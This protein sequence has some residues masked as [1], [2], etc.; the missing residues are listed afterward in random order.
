MEQ[1]A[2][3]V[4]IHYLYYKNH[5]NYKKLIP[6]KWREIKGLSDKNSMA[7][8]NENEIVLAMRGLDIK[9]L[10]DVGIGVNI[11]A[12]DIMNPRGFDYETAR[13]KYK[14]ILLQEQKKI[15]MIKENYP[16]KKLI[17]AG[18][19]RGGRKAV[20]LGMHNDVE[21]HGFNSGDASSLR[22]KIYSLAL[23]YILGQLDT[24]PLSEAIGYTLTAPSLYAE[25]FLQSG[26]YEGVSP[27]GIL[28]K[29]GFINLM[30]LH[31]P[32]LNAGLRAG[33]GDNPI[34]TAGV[35][36]IQD[37]IQPLKNELI[38]TTIAGG[39]P[40]KT[41]KY[42]FPDARLSG[43][44]Y[45]SQENMVKHLH[46]QGL[47][48]QRFSVENHMERLRRRGIPVDG[49][50]QDYAELKDYTGGI[51]GKAFN[52]EKNFIEF[53]WATTT[54]TSLDNKKI[55]EGDELISIIQKGFT[56]AQQPLTATQPLTKI[57]TNNGNLY[58]TE[59]DIVSSGYKGSKLQNLIGVRPEIVAPKDYV[60]GFDPTHHSIDHFISKELF[61]AIK[62]NET[63]TN[64]LDQD[65]IIKSRFHREE[66]YNNNAFGSEIGNVGGSGREKLNIN[67][68]CNAF[69]D[70][71]ECKFF[72]GSL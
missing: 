62:K 4:K 64:V 6:R 14:D 26:D 8:E 7:F 70:L 56:F 42:G 22:D 49:N 19:S 69:P 30:D 67:A 47:L 51:Y 40:L 16:D 72:M 44:E 54:Q 50:W 43:V 36:L 3:L 65:I 46:H 41:I 71:P 52:P 34:T 38:T 37:V 60:G 29:F 27:A 15:D 17:L 55:L 48:P 66:S 53:S 5:P 58:S 10:E 11:I 1:F 20:D 59:R 2:D 61:D 13:G 12:G 9:N 31:K 68:F 45:S 25:D 23:P 18:H 39:N 24:T 21:F 32:I 35:S 63:I 28:N 57:L 33:V